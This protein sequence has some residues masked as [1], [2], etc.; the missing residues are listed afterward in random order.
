MN[1]RHDAGE[2]AHYLMHAL[3]ALPHDLDGL[4]LTIGSVTYHPNLVNVIPNQVRFTV[5]M[6][7]PDADMLTMAEAR[8]KQLFEE[9]QTCSVTFNRLAFAPPCA[10]APSVVNAVRKA[11]EAG[12]F[13]HINMTSGAGHDAQIL[14]SC[15]PSGMI[16]I[17][18]KGGISHDVTEYSTPEHV[19]AG[20][21][22]LLGALLEL[23]NV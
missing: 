5:D 22:V 7:H 21:N 20:A 17:P 18:S 19:A 12:G 11:A 8:A 4:R 13:S 3:R 2:T 10:F 16:F 15:Y 14:Q 1:R 6:R 9:A 23:S